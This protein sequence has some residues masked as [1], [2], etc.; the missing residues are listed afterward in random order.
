MISKMILAVAI[1]AAACTAPALAGE[2]LPFAQG[3]LLAVVPVSSA[4]ADRRD[5]AMTTTGVPVS[6]A[7]VAM[8]KS[9]ARPDFSH[10]L[11]APQIDAA[12]RAFVAATIVI[13]PTG[14]G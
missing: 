12:W 8:P 13:P 5:A 7:V 6:A 14:G 3:S 2:N 11:S 9:P 1:A 4:N 10:A